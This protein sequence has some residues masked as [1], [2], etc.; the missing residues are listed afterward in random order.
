MTLLLK[1]LH[2]LRQVPKLWFI[3]SKQYLSEMGCKN[4][5]VDSG[6]YH[7]RHEGSPNFSTVCMD[8]ILITALEHNVN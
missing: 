8:D 6:V 7:M 5:Y 2:V 3:A 4:G 1:S